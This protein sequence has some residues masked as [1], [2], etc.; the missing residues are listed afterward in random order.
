MDVKFVKFDDDEKKYNSRRINK[1]LMK[2]LPLLEMAKA[3]GYTLQYETKL[4]VTP[5]ELEKKTIF[6][7]SKEIFLKKLT[8]NNAI[9]SKNIQEL[10]NLNEEK[11]HEIDGFLSDFADENETSLDT[12]QSVREKFE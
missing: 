9:I 6:K 1:D 3:A 8:E 10:F 7:T 5:P 2:I 4:T 11:I 12:V